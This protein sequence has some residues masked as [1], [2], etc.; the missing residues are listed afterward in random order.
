MEQCLWGVHDQRQRNLVMNTR[1]HPGPYNKYT[2][3]MTRVVYSYMYTNLEYSIVSKK[4]DECQ[5]RCPTR[6][7][8]CVG[9]CIREHNPEEIVVGFVVFVCLTF[10]ITSPA[11]P[12]R[13]VRLASSAAASPSGSSSIRS[14]LTLVVSPCPWDFAIFFRFADSFSR[15]QRSRNFA[16]ITFC[17]TLGKR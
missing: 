17:R 12:Y 4:T 7:F 2:C 8:V 16:I 11:I 9:V 5:E 1:S 14:P 15:S 10:L 6:L 3:F 13:S